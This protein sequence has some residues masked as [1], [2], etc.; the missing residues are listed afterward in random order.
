MRHIRMI[1]NISTMQIQRIIPL[2]YVLTNM[3][4]YPI[5]ASQKKFANTALYPLQILPYPP[6]LPCL[7]FSCDLS[8]LQNFFSARGKI[9]TR[10]LGDLVGLCRSLFGPESFSKILIFNAFL[11]TNFP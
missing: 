4:Q 8:P 9:L 2:P 7:Q 5:F 11:L 3:V 1:T 6:S 10:F